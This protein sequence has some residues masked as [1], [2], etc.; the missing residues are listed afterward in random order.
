M[1]KRFRS[2]VNIA[3][4][5][6]FPGADTGSDQDLL[7]MTF[8]LRLKKNQRAKTHKTQV[9]P[10]KAER[11]QR[12]GNLP[13]YDRREFCTPHHHEQ[14]RY[15]QIQWPPS[16]TQQWLKQP[17][18]SLANIVRRKKPWDTAEILDLCDKRRE[19]R[20]KRYEPKLS[21]K[22]KEVNEH[23]EVHEKRLKK[24]V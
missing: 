16:S 10:R 14:R 13:S 8:L 23:Q 7:M 1:R 15:R 19:L 22:D 5:R 24:T 20:K 6:S 4:T 21:A 12:V 18:R 17:V 2:R 11:S 9:W 3:R